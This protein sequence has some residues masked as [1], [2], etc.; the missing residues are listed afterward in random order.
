MSREII[1]IISVTLSNFLCM[2]TRVCVY[3][4]Y[5]FDHKWLLFMLYDAVIHFKM[6]IMDAYCQSLI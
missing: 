5:N 6:L 1:L 4:S 2:Y 3:V